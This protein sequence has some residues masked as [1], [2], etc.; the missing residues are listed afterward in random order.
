V[1]ERRLR[2]LVP[3]MAFPPYHFK[4]KEG[5]AS[6]GTPFYVD[7]ETIYRDDTWAFQGSLMTYLSSLS[8]LEH[9]PSGWD[10]EWTSAAARSLYGS[11]WTATVAEIG[12]DQAG[13]PRRHLMVN[14]AYDTHHWKQADLGLSLFWVTS[15]RLEM[16]SFTVPLYFDQLNLYVRKPAP[17]VETLSE[18][19]ASPFEPFEPALWATVSAG[20]GGSCDATSSRALPHTPTATRTR[21]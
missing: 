2:V 19:I 9:G 3:S 13:L 12:W 20:G 21:R 18:K 6:G 10:Y 16:A 15:D 4:S 8:S 14:G 11:A 5:L 1:N 17:R 7:N